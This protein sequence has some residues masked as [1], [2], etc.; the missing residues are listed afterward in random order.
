MKKVNKAIRIGFLAVAAASIGFAFQAIGAG[1][2]VWDS[3]NGVPKEMLI[4]RVLVFLMSSA[5][6]M[7]IGKNG[8]VDIS[9]WVAYCIFVFTGILFLLAAIWIFDIE[10][11]GR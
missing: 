6:V 7:A 9:E 11:W 5:R 10:S 8:K 2:A 1:W 4:P 3:G